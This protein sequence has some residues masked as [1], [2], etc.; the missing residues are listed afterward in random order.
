[1]DRDVVAR[2]IDLYVNS[3]SDNLGVEGEQAVAA[4]FSRA[5]KA[6]LMPGSTQPLMAY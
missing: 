1:M 5:E 3:F 4:L 2:H 6:G